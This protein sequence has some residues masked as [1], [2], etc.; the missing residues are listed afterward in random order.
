ML[1]LRPDHLIPRLRFPPS[2]SVLREVRQSELNIDAVRAEMSHHDSCVEGDLDIAKVNRRR[3][4]S[5][6]KN[7]TGLCLA[8]RR[9]NIEKGMHQITNVRKHALKQDVQRVMLLD[10]ESK[11]KT[12]QKKEERETAGQG[13]TTNNTFVMPPFFV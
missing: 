6:A 4:G 3:L 5:W 11:S 7:S 1:L 9:G 13:H 10:G 8:A 12:K 2:L